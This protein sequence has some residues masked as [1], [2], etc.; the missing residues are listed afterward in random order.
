[1]SEERGILELIKA[2]H[3]V[4]RTYPLVKLLLLGN[5]GTQDFEERC[6]EYVRSND[7][8][9]SVEFLGFV[10]H[11]EIPKYTDAADVGAV[12]LHPTTQFMK[13]AYPIK[14]FEYM[15]CGKTVIASN[16]PAMGKIVKEV[17]C[18][19]LVNPT[20]ID[21]IAEAIIYLI[22]HQEEAKKMGENG[23]RAVEE[24]YNWD[25]MEEKLLKLYRRLK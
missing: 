13:T 4:S 20:D 17:E 7:L 19:V 21:E 6:I 12:L 22:K 11:T 15:I 1:M 2:V 3:K 18:G 23:R 8:T 10:P 16:L 14:L 24:K 25:K 5:F 9:E